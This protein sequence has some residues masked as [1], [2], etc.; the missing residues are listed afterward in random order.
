MIDT[1]I[2]ILLLEDDQALAIALSRAMENRGHT[3]TWLED[4][5]TFEKYLDGDHN[6]DLILMDLK[7]EQG[8]SLN[9]VKQVRESY[10]QAKIFIVTGFASIATTVEAIKQ[11]ADDYLFGSDALFMFRIDITFEAPQHGFEFS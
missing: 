2:D 9:R 11:G 8:T 1:K 6:H 7:L 5:E 10:P 3:I 4:L